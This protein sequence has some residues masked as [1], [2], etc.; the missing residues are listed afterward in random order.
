MG[1][2]PIKAL[3]DKAS[4][5]LGDPAIH[6]QL[7]AVHEIGVVRSEEE[8]C[9]RNLLRA[10]NFPA[11]DQRREVLLCVRSQRIPYRRINRSRAK[12]I[13]PYFAFLQVDQPRPSKERTAALLAL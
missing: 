2:C 5:D 6:E 9:R 4:S 13:H 11:R 3:G 7:D 1:S 12:Y 8:R 10:P